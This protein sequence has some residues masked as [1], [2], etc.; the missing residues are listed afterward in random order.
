VID[1]DNTTIVGGAGKKEAIQARIAQ[2]RAQIEETT[3]DYDREKLQE[4]LAKLV[5]GVAILRVGAATEVEMKEKK[6]R[7]DDAMHATKA[8]VEEGIVPGGGVALL[9]AQAA[10]ANLKVEGDQA[11][12]VDIVRRAMEEP[13]RQIVSNAGGEPSV[14]VNRVRESKD[15][16]G[17]NALTGTYEPLLKAGVIDPAKVVR[18]AL[19]NAA[20][21]AGLLITTEAAIA[22]K[23]EKKAGAAAP[24]GDEDY[25]DDY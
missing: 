11:I 2:I 22:N 4:R 15:D 20:S 23:P 8:A 6:A 10:L 13:L 17:Y 12:G 24:G 18:S 9:R 21:V 14:V 7:V 3:S 5:G 16:F 19:Q 25:G 1:K